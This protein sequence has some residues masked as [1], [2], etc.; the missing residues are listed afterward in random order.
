MGVFWGF[1]LLVFLFC[2]SEKAETSSQKFLL[3]EIAIMETHEVGPEKM[4]TFIQS[5]EKL[6]V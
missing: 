2:Q 6:Y 5:E 3:S 4:S 1:F